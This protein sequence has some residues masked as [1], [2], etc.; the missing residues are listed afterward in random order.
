ML[1]KHLCTFISQQLH[2]I[3]LIIIIDRNVHKLLTI[4]SDA[5]S[6]T[7]IYYTSFYFTITM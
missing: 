5:V 7:H 3:A 4:V 6:I 2:V 1:L